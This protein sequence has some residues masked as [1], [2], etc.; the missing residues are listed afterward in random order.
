MT[1]EPIAIARRAF[2]QVVAE[3]P[4]TGPDGIRAIVRAALEIPPWDDDRNEAVN[5]VADGLGS[6]AGYP[7]A[8][9]RGVRKFQPLELAKRATAILDAANGND[10][11]TGHLLL[12]DV[13]LLL[14]AATNVARARLQLRRRIEP[15]ISGQGQLMQPSAPGDY[16]ETS[17]D[18][19]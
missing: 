13:I 12:R 14:P 8:L 3:Q 17:S 7:I 9:P 10:A 18:S 11:L 1:T 19:T 6:W 4:L 2:A 16:I 5:V 15:W